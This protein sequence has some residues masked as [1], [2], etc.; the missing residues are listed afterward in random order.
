MGNDYPKNIARFYDVIYNSLRDGVDNHYY[1]EKIAATKGAILEVG[2]GT[3][4]LFIPAL[5]NGADIYAIDNSKFMLERLKQ[6]IDRK[7]YFRLALQDVRDIKLEKKFDLI[8]S[9]F[10]VFSHLL[11]FKDQMAALDSI[12]YHL[13]PGG[14]LIFDLYVP[15]L[16]LLLH[17]FKKH[18][19]FEGEYEP[20]LLLRRIVDTQNDLMKQITHITFTLEWMENNKLENYKWEFDFR[21]FFRYE[22]ENLIKLSQFNTFAIFGDFKEHEL[23][24]ESKEF[25][26]HCIKS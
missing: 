5:E 14:R 1:F 16:E 18:I 17:G 8:I 19:D 26:I 20:G 12:F 7:F 21:Y 2:A 15:D 6:K 24:T 9:P 23:C 4:R 3:G 22:L 13:N 11:S 25:I 10:R